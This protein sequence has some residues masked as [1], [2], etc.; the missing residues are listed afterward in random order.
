MLA[1]IIVLLFSCYDIYLKITSNAHTQHYHCA[2]IGHSMATY[3]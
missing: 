1:I 2:I 3:Q